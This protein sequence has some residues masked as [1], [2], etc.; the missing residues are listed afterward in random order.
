MGYEPK[1]RGK[2]KKGVIIMNKIVLVGCGNVGMA[3]AY[4]L[5]TSGANV[6]ELCLID[7]NKEYVA[8][9]AQDLNDAVP[10]CGNATRVY[11]GE[12]EECSN[13][14]IVVICAGR[15]QEKGESRQKLIDKNYAVFDDIIS[16]I[17]PTGFDGIY[18]IAT[19]P[20]DVMTT[21]TQ[22]LSGFAPEKVIGSG[23]VLDTARLKF[24]IGEKINMNPRHVHAYV[25][26]EHGDSEFVAWN[27]ALVAMN[28][29]DFYLS[30]EEKTEIEEKVRKSAYEIINKKGYTCYGIGMSLVKITNAILQDSHEVLTVSAYDSAHD[31]YYSRPCVINRSGIQEIIELQLSPA[32]E[33]RLDASIAEIKNSYNAIPNHI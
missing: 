12:Y 17:A 21:I 26:G 9:Q 31:I 33:E 2:M 28:T 18:L 23:T 27:N 10:Y 22:K 15:N 5:L 30:N 1:V 24:Y 16:K 4:A 6:N 14:D 3:Y 25:I 20:L 11:A 19:N 13:A 8:G 7:I 29:A 32:D